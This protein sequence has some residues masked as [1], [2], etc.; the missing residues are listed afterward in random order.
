MQSASEKPEVEDGKAVSY[1]DEAVAAAEKLTNL[2]TGK[3]VS[4]LVRDFI[5]AKIGGDRHQDEKKTHRSSSHHKTSKHKKKKKHKSDHK[6]K[7]SKHHRHSKDKK[8]ND[9]L[10]VQHSS[11]GTV[12]YTNHDVERCAANTVPSDLYDDGIV[13][14]ESCK[15]ITECNLV[16]LSSFKGESSVKEFD[17]VDK[18]GIAGPFV[19]PPNDVLDAKLVCAELSEADNKLNAKPEELHFSDVHQVLHDCYSGAAKKISILK[20]VGIENVLG[21]SQ[22]ALYVQEK[23]SPG[24]VNGNFEDHHQN[25]T[26]DGMK[27]LSDPGLSNRV[28]K[29]S[30][31]DCKECNN[32]KQ[33]QNWHCEKHHFDETDEDALASIDHKEKARDGKDAEKN[34]DKI[35]ENT[36]SSSQIRS[37]SR[38]KSHKRSRSRRT[39][40]RRSKSKDKRRKRSRSLG[41]SRRSKKKEKSSKRSRTRERSQNMSTSKQKSRE[42]SRSR[43]RSQERSKSKQRGQ[44]RTRSQELSPKTSRSRG[45][46]TTR[47][48]SKEG[49]QKIPKSGETTKSRAK[50]SEKCWRR[51]RS[52]ETCRQKSRSGRTSHKRSRSKG[53]R[54]RRSRSIEVASQPKMSKISSNKD[55]IS[56]DNHYDKHVVKS[57]VHGD[58]FIDEA[59]SSHSTEKSSKEH[60]PVHEL[61]NS[62]HLNVSQKDR[63]MEEETNKQ[64]AVEEDCEALGTLQPQSELTEDIKLT[65]K[66]AEG[67]SVEADENR[68]NEKS[69][70]T[71]DYCQKKD[72]YAGSKKS[73]CEIQDKKYFRKNRSHQTV[74]KHD[75]LKSN[76]HHGSKEENPSSAVEKN[77]ACEKQK[78]KRKSNQSNTERSRSHE[79]SYDEKLSSRHKKA[80]LDKLKVQEVKRNKQHRRYSCSSDDT[81]ESSSPPRHRAKLERKSLKEP[82]VI[83]VS[84]DDADVISDK[85]MEKLHKRLT[86]SIKK[87]KELQAEREMGLASNLSAIMLI[88]NDE[89]LNHEA[90]PTCHSECLVEQRSDVTV[91]ACA[92]SFDISSIPD[93]P[94][95]SS[96]PPSVTT[97]ALHKV[98]TDDAT[99]AGSGKPSKALGL[100]KKSGLKLGLKISESSAARILLG[101]KGEALKVGQHMQA[102][103]DRC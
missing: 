89:E 46:S 65:S 70:D 50:S 43:E 37:C 26:D 101:L 76:D 19:K 75:R 15:G 84:D 99:K 39:S 88:T 79:C 41:T 2:S 73:A 91:D 24:F 4:D 53:L 102:G 64:V 47:S 98:A 34:E 35:E 5:I 29:Y 60:D 18:E 40:Q 7:N 58:I 62:T 94:M 57:G 13:T 83:Q 48:K 81:D 36:C 21:S 78:L 16:V 82:Y 6:K 49:S 92:I 71:D 22:K 87:S 12:E 25:K 56:K 17:S 90:P 63:N 85:M 96:P 66:R 38:K 28:E 30:D 45:T 52:E 33:E 27:R 93:I 14:S 74:S 59:L 31:D 68:S 61:G 9:S 100:G 51:S 103:A 69:V 20:N 42:R 55:G 67:K 97:G 1:A 80:E 77:D 10:S 8:D 86:T 3:P 32:I 72:E 54:Q 95:P 11:V 44:K 23:S